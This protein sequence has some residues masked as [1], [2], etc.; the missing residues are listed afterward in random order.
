MGLV[1]ALSA[2]MLHSREG[3]MLCWWSKNHL[4]PPRRYATGC[5]VVKVTFLQC[6]CGAGIFNASSA[7]L[8]PR[9]SCNAAQLTD[10]DILNFALN[11]EYLEAEYY[12]YATTG[13]GIPASLLGNGSAPT[14]GGMMANLSAPIQVGAR[15]LQLSSDQGSCPAVPP[16]EDV[17]RHV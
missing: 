9:S 13:S 6:C 3:E 8:K 1:P 16:Q 4:Q 15:S 7:R 10:A 11:L 17:E 5:T 14:T 2:R 12:T